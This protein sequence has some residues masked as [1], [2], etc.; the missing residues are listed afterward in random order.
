MLVFCMH[1]VLAGPCSELN[2]ISKPSTESFLTQH[3]VSVWAFVL[4]LVQA[5][6]SAEPQTFACSITPGNL[7]GCKMKTRREELNMAQRY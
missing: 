1:R 4:I 6:Q 3:L 2:D 5:V 7:L